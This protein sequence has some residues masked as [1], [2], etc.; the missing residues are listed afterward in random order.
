M[1][2]ALLRK[3]LRTT[4]FIAYSAAQKHIQEKDVWGTL[5]R[6]LATGF[7]LVAEKENDESSAILYE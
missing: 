3:L 7:Q 1:N 2:V 4:K 5:F 6:A